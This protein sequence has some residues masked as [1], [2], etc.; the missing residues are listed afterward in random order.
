MFESLRYTLF[1]VYTRISQLI[2]FA[3]VFSNVN[4][5][6]KRNQFLTANLL[7]QGYWY[8]KLH[9]GFSKFY[10]RSSLIIKYNVGLITPLQKA[11]QSQHFMSIYLIVGNTS[12]LISSNSLTIFLKKSVCLVQ[13]RNMF[14]ALISHLIAQQQTRLQIQWQSCPKPFISWSVT[15]VSLFRSTLAHLEGFLFNLA[16]S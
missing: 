2:R 1:G 7:K 4:D 16:V 13:N 11:F 9:K 5:F 15:D 12:F 6:N 14:L 3:R 8:N 10:L